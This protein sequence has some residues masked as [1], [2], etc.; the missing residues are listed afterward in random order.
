MIAAT[1]S[2]DRLRAIIADMRNLLD[3]KDWEVSA[4]KAIKHIWLSDCDSLVSHLHN[5][6]DEKMTNARLSIDIA[7]LKQ[8]LWI[9]EDGTQFENSPKATDADTLIRWIDTSTMACD[10]LTKKMKPDVLWAVFAGSLDLTPTAE[11]MLVELR[12]QKIR[13]EKAT[14]EAE[15]APAMMEFQ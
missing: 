5:P 7:G 3:M 11:S 14:R 15:S 1:D 9:K 2:G 6:K 10:P 12:K 4:K 13:R 8:Q